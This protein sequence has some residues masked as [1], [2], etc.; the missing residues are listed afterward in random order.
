MTD[1]YSCMLY[2]NLYIIL[3]KKNINTYTLSL[4]AEV[5]NV[6]V[7]RWLLGDTTGDT[8]KNRSTIKYFSSKV[9]SV[10]AFAIISFTAFSQN[11]D[12]EKVND[13]AVS[14]YERAIQMLQDGY[15]KEA[16]PFLK[17]STELQV[18]FADAYLSLGGAYGEL[19]DYQNSV[20][21]YEKAKS[22]DSVYFLYYNLPYSIN[23]AGLGNFDAAMNAVERFLAIPKLSDKSLKSATYRKYCYT[24]ALDYA[25]KHPE[26]N[27]VFAPENLGDSINSTFSEYYPSF[28]IDDSTLVFTRR[29]ERHSGILFKAK[30]QRT[31]TAK[32]RRLMAH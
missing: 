13:K 8:M 25:S 18:N 6:E 10:F 27:Y 4:P 28:T 16:I 5:Q 24:F 3:H 9:F 12:P 19:K 20:A 14:V 17:K 29:G 22:I 21:A 23:L 7:S 15:I 2:K 11:Y 31:V 30:K 1:I 32:Q 26:K